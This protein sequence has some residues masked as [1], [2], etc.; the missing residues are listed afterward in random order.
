M[1]APVGFPVVR[2]KICLRMSAKTPANITMNQSRQSSH[3][4]FA[5]SV[6]AIRAL[7]SFALFGIWDTGTRHRRAVG[8]SF[9]RRFLPVFP[10][11]QNLDRPDFGFVQQPPFSHDGTGTRNI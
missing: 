9:L 3:G 1:S 2:E 7:W 6:S 11:A 8:S 10:A 5:V 4:A